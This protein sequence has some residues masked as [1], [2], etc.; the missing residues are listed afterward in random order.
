MVIIAK[1]I[2][3][4][5]IIKK[6]PHKPIFSGGNKLHLDKYIDQMEEGEEF[7]SSHLSKKFNLTN[8]GTAGGYLRQRDDVIRLKH[9][10][11]RKV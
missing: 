11:W 7:Y 4:D 9:G 2:N 8:S 3:P 6:T 5:L 1:K 10:R